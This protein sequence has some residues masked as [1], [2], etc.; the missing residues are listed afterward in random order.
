MYV[1]NI[2]INYYFSKK[3]DLF[4]IPKFYIKYNININSPFYL[5]S[6]VLSAF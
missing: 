2:I 6:R 4:Y 1:S 5:Y 3:R